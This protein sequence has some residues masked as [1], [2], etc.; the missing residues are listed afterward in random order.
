[1]SACKIPLVCASEA[2][3]KRILFA[4]APR[5]QILLSEERSGLEL[6]LVEVRQEKQR[7]MEKQ[8]SANKITSWLDDIKQCR[9][10]AQCCA[11]KGCG[12]ILVHARVWSSNRLWLNCALNHSVARCW[13][14]CAC[15]FLEIG[16]I[17]RK[18]TRDELGCDGEDLE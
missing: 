8:F 9:V 7:P 10:V 13:T 5:S 11:S 2:I 14:C 12:P 15:D 17:P 3:C 18:G 6:D 16:V 4:F 1:M